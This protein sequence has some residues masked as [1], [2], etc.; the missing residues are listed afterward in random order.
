MTGYRQEHRKNVQGYAAVAPLAGG[1]AGGGGEGDEK[2]APELESP[3]TAI[4]GGA[5]P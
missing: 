2:G 5:S 1:S 3:K 4:L